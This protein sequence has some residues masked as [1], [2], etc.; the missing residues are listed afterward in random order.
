MPTAIVAPVPGLTSAQDVGVSI[1]PLML[2]AVLWGD[3]AARE[4]LADIHDDPCVQSVSVL[5]DASLGP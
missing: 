5:S 2:M 1:D 3:V 4:A